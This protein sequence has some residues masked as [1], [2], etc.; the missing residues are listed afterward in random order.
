M[1]IYKGG[2]II[3]KEGLSSSPSGLLF[4]PTTGGVSA[5]FIDPPLTASEVQVFTA[6]VAPE[7]LLSPSL[8]ASTSVTYIPEILGA[9][10]T[11][12]PLI[13]TAETDTYNPQVLTGVYV[14]PSITSAETSVNNHEVAAEQILDIP[15]TIAETSIPLFEIIIPLTLDMEITAS[16]VLVYRHTILLEGGDIEVVYGLLSPVTSSLI[17][18]LIQPAIK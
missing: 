11:I 14:D 2:L 5:L 10:F 1:K 13:V 12:E 18:S 7:Q 4:L 15:Q 3:P 9:A 17:D 6:E 8:I 16:T